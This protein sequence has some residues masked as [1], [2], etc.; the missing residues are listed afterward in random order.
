MA[1]DDALLGT[2]QEGDIPVIRLYRFVPPSISIG[3]LQ[4]SSDFDIHSAEKDGLGFIR[5]PTGGMA[6]LHD[7][8][9]TY[10]FVFPKSFFPKFGKRQVYDYIANALT[11]CLSDLSVQ[12]HT[13]SG[14]KG[15][16]K[17]ADCYASTGEYEI[18]DSTGKKLIGSAQ[19]V[20]R[21]AVLQHGSIPIDRSRFTL[22]DY[23][24]NG[25]SG[26]HGTTIKAVTGK[27]FTF[28]QVEASFISTFSR[29]FDIIPAELSTTE[30][31]AAK[32][33]YNSRYAKTEWNEK[34]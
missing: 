16:L 5:R 23:L 8:E 19:M 17:S 18:E 2:I 24:I 7:V 15:D 30:E 13:V 3:R 28:S 9:L 33:L 27:N 1:R 29:I 12:A 10:S 6:V 31:E 22:K 26:S 20:S 4:R 11:T 14:K 25:G 21:Q 32:E 34:Y